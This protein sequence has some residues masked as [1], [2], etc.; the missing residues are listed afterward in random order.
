MFAFRTVKF[1]KGFPFP[2]AI[3]KAWTVVYFEPVAT[4]RPK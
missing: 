3:L 4:G 1:P 2:N